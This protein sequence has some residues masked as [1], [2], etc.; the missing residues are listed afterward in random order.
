MAGGGRIG[1]PPAPSR[2]PN[3]GAPRYSPV[4]LQN[5]F[6]GAANGSVTAPIP[7]TKIAECPL[8]PRWKRISKLAA[9]F[10]FL[11]FL[12]KGIAWLVVGF[13][14]WKGVT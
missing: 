6:P 14:A 9:Q 3:Y 1:P 2:L 8:S 11:F 4:V 13:I 7:D 5:D 12:L 10:G